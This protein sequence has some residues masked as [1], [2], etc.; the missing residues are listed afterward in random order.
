MGKILL[1][2]KYV[3]LGMPGAIAKWQKKL[4]QDLGLTGRIIIATEGINGTVGSIEATQ[5]YIDAMNA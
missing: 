2:Y 5:A 3:H 4:C 1:F